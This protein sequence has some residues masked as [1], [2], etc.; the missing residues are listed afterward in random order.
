[1]PET[2]DIKCATCNVA[3]QGNVAEPKPDD[4]VTCP[5]CGASDTRENVM[6]EIGEYARDKA[7]DFIARGFKNATRGSKHLTFKEKLRPKK[8]YRFIVDLDLH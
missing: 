3:L 8:V 4:V 1:M 2:K 5:S 6:R 7:S